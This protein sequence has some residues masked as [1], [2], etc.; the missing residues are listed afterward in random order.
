LKIW[1]ACLTERLPL[2]DASISEYGSN[3]R[4]F[5]PHKTECDV[6]LKTLETKVVVGGSREDSG[7]WEA[8][9]RPAYLPGFDEPTLE[10]STGP[11]EAEGP[12]PEIRCC[13]ASE[14]VSGVV[15]L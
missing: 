15:R 11:H 14:N 9:A 5:T 10:I 13:R 1:K 2:L 4:K 8:G 6:E 12:H 7:S 3:R